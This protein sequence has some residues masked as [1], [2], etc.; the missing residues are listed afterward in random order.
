MQKNKTYSRMIGN[1]GVRWNYQGIIRVEMTLELSCIKEGYIPE[2]NIS[3]CEDCAVKLSLYAQERQLRAWYK[4]NIS[5]D[6]I[7]LHKLF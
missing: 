5:G 7:G 1:A 6:H 2:R 3:M 4:K